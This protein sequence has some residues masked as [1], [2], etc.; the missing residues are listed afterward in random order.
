MI[1]KSIFINLFSIIT[2]SVI[3]FV[4]FMFSLI[5]N[6]LNKTNPNLKVGFPLNYYY[7]INVSNNLNGFDLLHGT[8]PRN[9]V[10]NYIFCLLL[11]LTLN[12]FKLLNNIKLK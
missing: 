3:S 4:S 11:I 6:S 8:N 7:Q 9:F 10:L 5:F 2:F 12:N 1:R